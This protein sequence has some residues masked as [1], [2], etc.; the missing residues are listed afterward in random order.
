MARAEIRPIEQ[1]SEFR[2]DELFFSTTDKKGAIASGND[3]FV[4][5]SG[6]NR[7]DLIGQPHNIIRHPDMPRCV[8]R[9]LWRTI[10]ENQGIVAYVKNMAKNGAYYWVV[11]L[12]FPVDG[13]YLSIRFKPSSEI[14]G[15]V[16]DLYRE[17]LACEQ[18]AEA[19]N[20][21]RKA[22]MEESTAML[23]ERL[24]S[25][26]F[27]D[28]RSFMT[29]A[30]VAELRSRENLLKVS[31]RSESKLETSSSPVASPLLEYRSQSNDLCNNLQSLFSRF[32]SFSELSKALEANAS[33]V[34]NLAFAMQLLAVNAA[35]ESSKLGRVGATMS[36]VAGSIARTTSEIADGISSMDTAASR[37]LTT[38]NSIGFDIGTAKLQVEL[39]AFYV[40]ECLQKF[41]NGEEPDPDTLQNYHQLL[42]LLAQALPHLVRNAFVA[43]KT[44]DGDLGN[45]LSSAQDLVKTSQSLEFVHMNGRIETARLGL[46]TTFG[47][48]LEAIK[49]QLGSTRLQFSELGMSVG[50][51]RNQLRNVTSLETGAAYC[52][53]SMDDSLAGLGRVR[54]ESKAPEAA[55]AH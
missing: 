7:E 11:A 46:D 38:I 50:E 43:V 8:F 32:S 34:S 24:K 14:F 52:L 22:A 27:A 25:L 44:F 5:V 39:S 10:Q 45:L 20:K 47:P 33:F 4:R 18:Q 42:R 19:A 35:I 9:L 31:S 53:R 36:V 15:V 12:V 37:L 54:R 6:Y 40:N 1:E 23:L 16:K 13:G 28:Y 26:G 29:A 55:P 3:V 2:I 48:M 30:F 41:A 49:E 21:G 17:L 51:F